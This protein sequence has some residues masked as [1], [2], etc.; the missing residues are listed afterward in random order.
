MVIFEVK[1]VETKGRESY[2]WILGL[3]FVVMWYGVENV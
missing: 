3:N 1:L 2:I